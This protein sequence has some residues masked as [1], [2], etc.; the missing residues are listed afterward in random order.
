MPFCFCDISNL[1]LQS[2]GSPSQSSLR[3]ASSPKVGAFG[4]PCKLH[5]YAKASH[6]G[7]GVTEGDGEGEAVKQN[8]QFFL[9]N[10]QHFCESFTKPIDNLPQPCYFSIDKPVFVHCFG[11]FSKP[12]E[13]AFCGRKG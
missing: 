10:V 13:A 1:Y 11:A 9:F 4:S 3:D 2:A 5:L 7:R 8:H 12:E 6:F